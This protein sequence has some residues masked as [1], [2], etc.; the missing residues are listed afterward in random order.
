MY[1]HDTKT[2]ENI[3]IEVLQTLKLNVTAQT[4]IPQIRIKQNEFDFNGAIGDTKLLP[5]KSQIH[6]LLCHLFLEMT[7]NDIYPNGTFDIQYP[8][9]WSDLT[10]EPTKAPIMP[11][12]PIDDDELHS[13][14]PPAHGSF[15]REKSTKSLHSSSSRESGIG[16]GVRFSIADS[17]SIKSS[18]RS[19]RRS[20]MTSSRQS[21]KSLL[22]TSD[23]TIIPSHY[24]RIV[25]SLENPNSL[26]ND[27]DGTNNNQQSLENTSTALNIP[28]AG[29]GSASSKKTLNTT[30]SR[31]SLKSPMFRRG[32]L[33]AMSQH[34]SMLKDEEIQSITEESNN[35]SGDKTNEKH[36]EIEEIESEKEEIRYRILIKPNGTLRF[37]LVF[38]PKEIDQY[39]F[40]LNL[41]MAGIAYDDE[42]G[43]LLRKCVFGQGLKP[44]IALSSRNISFFDVTV[45][46]EL[47]AKQFPYE[48]HV[49]I[50][51]EEE[52]KIEWKLEIQVLCIINI[53]IQW[54]SFHGKYYQIMFI[55]PLKQTKISIFFS[56]ITDR[57]YR[58]N[59][60]L[61]LSN[62]NNDAIDEDRS[63]SECQYVMNKY[64]SIE[65]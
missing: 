48:K 43:V 46:S 28:G 11:L 8:Q 64:V 33:M 54:I 41:T 47:K 14:I 56:P 20:L 4:I 58:D 57:L 12:P 31:K 39:D 51:N 24:I 27:H 6:P 49:V 2:D 7:Q 18:G 42:D 35:K 34:I 37:K 40:D 63:Q 65:L 9:E 44:R 62:K 13:F 22:A 55:E 30:R 45:L 10:T 16:G 15:S 61:L 5:L 1:N 17:R 25:R 19:S 52:E 32:S 21:R 36:V 38:N 23:G 26:Q 50:T 53:V 60:D 3:I 29:F 59:M